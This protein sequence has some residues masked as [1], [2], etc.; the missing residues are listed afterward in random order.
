MPGHGRFVKQAR[1]RSRV[2]HDGTH[3]HSGSSAS[4][5]RMIM[6]YDY[7]GRGPRLQSRTSRRRD[8]ESL[9]ANEAY[10]LSC[11]MLGAQG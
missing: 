1:R 6:L 2:A 7:H 11:R 3:C 5:A 10:R 8:A 9:G 4:I